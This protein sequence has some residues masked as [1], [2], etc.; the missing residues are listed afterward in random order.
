MSGQGVCPSNW[1]AAKLNEDET[2]S[3]AA[4]EMLPEC[5]PLDLSAN[6]LNQQGNVWH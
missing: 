1:R 5:E 2:E 6:S 4:E 3:S